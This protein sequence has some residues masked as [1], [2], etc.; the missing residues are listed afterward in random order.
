MASPSV[1]PSSKLNTILQIIQLALSGLGTVVPGAALAG[2][3]VT[4]FQHATALY[5]A[6]TGQPF[7]IT[8][9]P[10]ESKLP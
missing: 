7:D 2:V 6:E 1:T 10:M 9:I 3:F 5:Q 4:I 8:K